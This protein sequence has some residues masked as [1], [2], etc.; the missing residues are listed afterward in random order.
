MLALATDI[1]GTEV[2]TVGC[3]AMYLCFKQSQKNLRSYSMNLLTFAWAH[4]TC[5]LWYFPSLL[6]IKKG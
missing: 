6:D 3:T 2:T 4:A 1:V 5:G